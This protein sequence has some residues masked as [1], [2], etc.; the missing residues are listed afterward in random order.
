M[1]GWVLRPQIQVPLCPS[2]AGWRP[3]NTHPNISLPCYGGVGCRKYV[4]LGTGEPGFETP[5]SVA[6]CVVWESSA[7]SP[8]PSASHL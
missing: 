7:A 8:G 1:M 5:L 4:D 6:S 2:G 3:L